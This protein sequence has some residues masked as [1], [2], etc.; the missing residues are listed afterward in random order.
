MLFAPAKK[1]VRLTHRFIRPALALTALL[2]AACSFSQ[3]YVLNRISQADG[4]A[5]NFV[6]CV[7]QDKKGFIWIGSDNGLQRYD[8]RSFFSPNVNTRTTLPFAAVN[9]IMEDGKGRMW[10]RCGNITGIFDPGTFRFRMAAVNKPASSEVDEQTSLC[11]DMHGNMYLLQK[12]NTVLYFDEASFS[13]DE[14]YTPYKFPKA[15][16]ILVTFD[17]SATRRTWLGCYRQLACYDWQS[18][19]LWY[20]GN[21]PRNLPLLSDSIRYVTSFDIDRQRKY[22][23]SFWRDEQTF[24]CFDEKTNRYVADTAGLSKNHEKGYFEMKHITSFSDSIRMAYGINV[25]QATSGNAF[26]HMEDLTPAGSL[27]YENIEQVFEDRNGVIWI[28]SDNG[29]YNLTTQSRK[30]ARFEVP[31]KTGIVFNSACQLPDGDILLYGFGHGIF[32]FDEKLSVQRPGII[33]AAH[34][35]ENFQKSWCLYNNP[36]DSTVWIGCQFGRLMIYEFKTGRLNYYHPAQFRTWTMTRAL[37]DKNGYLWVGLSNG[38]I[39]RIKQRSAITDTAF[40]FMCNVTAAV[41]EMFFHTDG[42]LYVGTRGAGAFAVSAATGKITRQY[43]TSSR[44]K[45]TTNQV[46]DLC[47]VNDSIVCFSGDMPNLVNIRTGAVTYLSHYND[48]MLGELYVQIPDKNNDIWFVSTN[49]FYRYTHQRGYLQ[50]FTQREGLTVPNSSIAILERRLLRNGNILLAGN[51]NAMLFN[52]NNYRSADKPANVLISNFRLG[53]TYLPLDSI[54]AL[55][56]VQLRRD[57]NTLAISF[58]IPGFADPSHHIYLYRLEG[59]DKDW[60]KAGDLREARYSLLPPGTYTF[61]V[62]AQNAEGFF[63]EHTTALRIVIHPPFWKT[64]WFMALAVAALGFIAYQLHRLRIRQ[65]LRIEKVRSRLA[66]DLH[67]DMGS[68][69]STINILTSIAMN[70]VGKS[71]QEVSSHLKN[72]GQS[73]SRVMEAMDDIVWSI[74]PRNDNMRKIAARMREFASSTLEAQNIR[75]TFTIDEA[76]KELKFDMESRK[77]IFLLFKEAINNIAKYAEARA[78]GITLQLARKA[79]IMRIADDGK[80]FDPSAPLKE[81][82]GNGLRNMQARAEA[83]KGRLTI[84]STPGKG[85]VVELSVGIR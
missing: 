80:G 41:T 29:L 38:N 72:I 6:H 48:E 54:Q 83:I 22:W 13:F 58:A 42:N 67:D 44:T 20:Y 12:G 63:S 74:N 5:S 46:G 9:Q 11:R 65:L 3:T 45:L 57:Q 62:R 53:N 61:R 68:T 50:K 15:W 24:L 34:P 84:S 40:E 39:L 26:R 47:A 43:T 2:M 55:Q 1:R 30:A 78:V 10:I 21:N 17:D 77:D 37:A 14:R 76:V 35:D 33:K 27:Q 73:S 70:K 32:R 28:A 7:W 64:W 69:L 31:K 4:L 51:L 18:K 81:T 56:T 60:V 19:Q 52:P 85:T 66:S 75:L 16:R 79:F 59:A 23:L 8:G 82:R 71:D 49:G 25:F 36:A